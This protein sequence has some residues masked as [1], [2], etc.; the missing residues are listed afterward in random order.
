MKPQFS[1][2]VEGVTLEGSS[3]TQLIVIFVD[4]IIK[5]SRKETKA[6]Y[7]YKHPKFKKSRQFGIYVG[8]YL[9]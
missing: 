7:V 3:S 8:R 6:M 1:N 9:I 2:A 4:E 5:K